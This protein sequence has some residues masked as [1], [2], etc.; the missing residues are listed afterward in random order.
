[1]QNG[2]GL[3][4]IAARL[5]TFGTLVGSIGAGL[6]GASAAVL[7]PL[8]AAVAYFSSVG[9]AVEKMA[10]R[11]GMSAEAVS[12]FG[13]AADLSGTDIGTVETAVRRMQQTIS[14]AATG[15]Q[16][17]AEALGRLGL[18]ASNLVGLSPDQQLA[19]LA[20]K[21]AAIQDPAQRT[22]VAMDIFGRSGTQLL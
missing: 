5:R 13:H 7:G 20:D 14:D 21:I 3:R 11:T 15:A 2:R 17:S 10:A 19:A 8:V 9:D 1:L 16:M 22:A 4:Q 18:S 12:E 6:S